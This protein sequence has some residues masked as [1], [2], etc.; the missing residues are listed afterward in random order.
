MSNSFPVILSYYFESQGLNRRPEIL[1][2]VE[3]KETKDYLTLV[4]LNSLLRQSIAV[5]SWFKYS[6]F[7]PI[8]TADKLELK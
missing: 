3:V 2:I 1:N 5:H 7:L 8:L 6:C 4:N